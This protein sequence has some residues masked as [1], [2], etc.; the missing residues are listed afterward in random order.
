VISNHA[1]GSTPLS[2]AIPDLD[3]DGDLDV[4]TANYGANTLT[5]ARGG[6]DGSF[7][8]PTTVP[9]GT[10]PRMVVAG[11]LDGDGYPDLVVANGGA[12]TLSVLRVECAP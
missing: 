3:R 9:V 11:D 2:V 4:I 5:V 6:G 10:Q 1:A 12:N 8:A 7:G